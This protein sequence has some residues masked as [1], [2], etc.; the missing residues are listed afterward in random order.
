MSPSSDSLRRLWRCLL[1]LCLALFAA[2]ACV[3]LGT[4]IP[5]M[6]GPLLA[7]SLASVL[8]AR[9]LSAN[10]LRNS[11]QWV[12]GTA[13]GLYFTPVV[14]ALVAS[15]W[16]AIGLGIAWALAL[17]LA[18]S[19]CLHRWHA[20]PE[21]GPGA[22]QWR[23]TTYF[24]GAI[25]GA[26]EM[27]LIAE[28]RGARTDLVASAHSLRVLLVTVTIPFVIQAWGV[29]GL[30]VNL[31]GVR[32]VQWVGLVQLALWTLAGALLM[33]RLG[34][35]NPWFMGALVVTMV[36]TL[37]G[38]ELSAIPVWLTNAAQLVI[39]VSL[40]VRFTPGFLRTAP[41]W[42]ASVAAATGVMMLVCAIFAWGLAR[43]TDLPWATLVLG[44]SPGG[45]AEMAITAKVLELG[46]P[47]VTA[48][49][50]CRLVAVLVLAEPVYAWLQRRWPLD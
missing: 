11:G 22:A 4:P 6:I 26:S 27:T 2:L 34:R 32:E 19:F 5:W 44:T 18:F 42:L 31:P 10:V 43:W 17:G 25:G 29:R 39:G 41:R 49:Q 16:W 35:A 48:F 23:A 21:M 9:T 30:D 45:I 40:G 38:V 15:L 8:G 33:Q 12:I 20:A 7:T 13:L 14:G 50:V 36:L 24:A 37:S 3:W 1:T 28:R 47:V 46:V